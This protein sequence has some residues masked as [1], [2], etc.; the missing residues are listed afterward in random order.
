MSGK[1]PI[2][3]VIKSSGLG[4]LLT[5]HRVHLGQHYLVKIH[6]NDVCLSEERVSQLVDKTIGDN[7]PLEIQ[8]FDESMQAEN[9]KPSDILE[10]RKH[11][12]LHLLC[13]VKSFWKHLL[14]DRQIGMVVWDG[15]LSHA[16]TGFEASHFVRMS[17][18]ARR[19]ALTVLIRA[20]SRKTKEKESLT[21]TIPCI[22]APGTQF[23]SRGS[24]YS[25]KFK[26]PRL[27]RIRGA[28]A[29]LDTLIM[30]IRKIDS[31]AWMYA[32]RGKR[33]ALDASWKHFSVLKKSLSSWSSDF[34][35]LLKN[36]YCNAAIFK[37]LTDQSLKHNIQGVMLQDPRI[38]TR[39]RSIMEAFSSTRKKRK[40]LHVVN[41]K[42]R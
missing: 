24:L 29:Y 37:L 20:A 42:A 9:I 23:S 35:P 11:R 25:Q 13:C 39:Q 27:K 40:T 6:W 32:K 15:F 28:A 38:E 34:V 12:G 36:T 18:L 1:E 8:S 2:S 5:F 3:I 4:P 21:G 16:S 14:D 33:R 10:W 26:G 30:Q 22:E 41:N 7:T 17:T 31:C 19:V